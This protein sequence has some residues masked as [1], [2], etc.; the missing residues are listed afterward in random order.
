MFCH[1]DVKISSERYMTQITL[2]IRSMILVFLF[3]YAFGNGKGKEELPC[4]YKNGD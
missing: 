3:K 4:S 2:V 1:V